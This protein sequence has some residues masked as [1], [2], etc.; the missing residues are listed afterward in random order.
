MSGRQK[1]TFLMYH[2]LRI[3]GRALASDDPGYVRYVIDESA[4]REQMDHIAARELKALGVSDW[5]D[6]AALDAPVVVITFDDGSETDLIAA[7]PMLRER[8]FGATCYLTVDF[9]GRRGF[10]SP[11]Q[12]TELAASGLEVGCHSMSHAFLS[13]LDHTGLRREIVEAKDRLE[14]ICGTRVRSFSCPG[15]RYDRRVVPLARAAGYDSVTTS[16]AVP[17]SRSAHPDLLGR[18]AIVADTPL[19]QFEAL[20]SGRGAGTRQ[21]RDS[22]LSAAKAVLGNTVYEKLR[23]RLLG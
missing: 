22:V 20:I 11:A 14:Q 17:N 13:D 6:G 8:G 3:G 2:E 4:F 19:A 23:A 12:A 18:V 9:L 21:L 15:G 7:L 5:I 16:R 1:T 10:L